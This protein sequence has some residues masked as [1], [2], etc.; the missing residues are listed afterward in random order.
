MRIE[1]L[2]QEVNADIKIKLGST[3]LSTSKQATL[4]YEVKNVKR[5]ICE[6]EERCDKLQSIVQDLEKALNQTMHSIAD[7][8]N[9]LAMQQRM[10]SV[11]NIRGEILPI[12]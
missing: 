4:D 3:D 5:I 12:P 2:L 8:E 10:A 1:R 6:T 9:Q 7:I 11:Q